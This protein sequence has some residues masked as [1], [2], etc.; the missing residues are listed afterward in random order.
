MSALSLLTFR[1]TPDECLSG[2]E[3]DLLARLTS[4]EGGMAFGL[5]LLATPPFSID[6]PPH[7]G[8]PARID[9]SGRRVRMTHAGFAAE[10]DPFD[11]RIWLHRA[12]PDDTFPLQATLRTTLA[13][14]LPLLGG[15]TVHCAGVVIDGSG[16]L[17]YGQSGAG[18]STLAGRS[19]YP[20]LSDEMVAL[21]ERDGELVV[22][23]TGFWGTLD[24]DDAPR[25]SFPLASLTRI[26]KGD[27]LRIDRQQTPQSFLEA[28]LVPAIPELWSA[29]LSV[30]WNVLAKTPH[31]ELTWSLASDP[32]KRLHEMFAVDSSESKE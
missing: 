25:G 27:S 21:F 14:V 10:V 13:S 24:R 16:H 12:D 2:R 4:G 30:A 26:R 17:F 28:L 15:V 8:E 22:S 7:V 6:D 3:R 32:W 11:R 19:P 18:K 31:Y 9:C 1:V 20:I 29:A 23:A 5:E